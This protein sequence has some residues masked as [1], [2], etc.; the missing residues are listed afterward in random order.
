[1][2]QEDDCVIYFVIESEIRISFS[3]ALFASGLRTNRR[4]IFTSVLGQVDFQLL[5]L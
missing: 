5:L 3:F 1:M 2:K 4:H